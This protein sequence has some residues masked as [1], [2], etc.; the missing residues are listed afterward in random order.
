M[1][2]FPNDSLT[3]RK[4]YEIFTLGEYNC[5]TG[6][7]YCHQ[8]DYTVTNYL[9]TSADTFELSR[10]ITPFANTG[11]PRFP[12]TWKQV[13]IFDVTD[14]YPYLVDSAKVR[15]LYSGYS[16]GFTANVKFAFIEGTPEKNVEGIDPL[17]SG[18]YTYGNPSDPIA[19]HIAQRYRTVP[20][21]TQTSALK[22]TVTG[23]G[24]DNTTQCCEFSSHSYYVYL[25][26]GII[27]SEIHLA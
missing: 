16:G 12:S 7:T 15:I 19:N 9:I 4:I 6:S 17:W 10:F 26:S 24:S 5:P 8:W 1:V 21:N 18:T 22:F 25:D 3:Y 20:V 14:F 13:Y 2:K 23:H 27:A 11:T